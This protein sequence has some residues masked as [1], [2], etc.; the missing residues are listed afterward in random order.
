MVLAAVLAAG[1]GAR[2]H[3]ARPRVGD[4]RRA[5]AHAGAAGGGD[6]ELAADRDRARP[7][8]AGARGGRRSALAAM[9]GLALL[10]A[11]RP[12]SSRRW[13]WP[14]CRSACRSQAGGRTANL[15]VPLYVVIGAGALA[16]LVPR[17]AR[18]GTRARRPSA[19]GRWSGCC[20]AASCSTRVQSL[21]ADDAAKAFE[22]VV[23]FYVPFALLFVL[24]RGMEWTPRRLL[25][26]G[27]A[28]VVLA[29]V[30]AG[31]RL[32][33]VRDAPPAA[34]PEGDR[35]QPGRGVLP[36]QLAV[37]RPEH[38][39][40]LPGAGDARA[41]G[42]AAVG[43]SARATLLLAIGAL[44]RALGRAADDALAV[45]LRRAAAR[46]GR[47]RRGCASAA[48]YVLAPALVAVVGG[49]GARLRVP[50]RAAAGRSRLRVARRRHLRARRPDGG[51]RGPRAREA[52][53]RLG[54]G[55]LQRR[56]PPR[57][58]RAPARE[59]TSASHT[60]PITVAAEQ[61]LLGLA[62]YV[63]LLVLAFRR[64]L[65]GARGGPVRAAIA[66]RL[67]RAGAAHVAL[68]G[69]PRGPD[70]VDAARAGLG[71]GGSGAV[72][73]RAG[74]G[75]RRGSERAP[76]GARR[77][78]PQRDD[79]R[80][81]PGARRRWDFARG[82]SP[83]RRPRPAVSAARRIGRHAGRLRGRARVGGHTH[84]SELRLLLPPGVGPGAAQ[85]LAA[86]LRGLRRADRSIRSTSWS[87][88]CWAA[89]SAR[90][91]TARSCWS[92]FLA[93]AALVLGTYRLG[94]AV[95]GRWSGALAALFVAASA[96]F[97]LYAARGY[98]DLPFLALVVWAARARGR[99]PRAACRSLLVAGR[100]AAPEAWVLAG[101]YWLWCWCATPRRVGGL[102]ARGRPP[103]CSGALTTWSSPATRSTRCTPRARWPTT[104]GA[105]A[106]SQRVPGSFVSF[107]GATVRPPVALLAPARRVVLA[108]RPRPARACTCR[109]RCSPPACSRSSAPACS[110]SRSCRAT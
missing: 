72:A 109:W 8:G 3:R 5:R 78:R 71:A 61:G 37:L 36:R 27:G 30:F 44:R 28:L 24:L 15:L 49:G 16:W 104:S 101:L 93:H 86:V 62:A 79:R 39:R 84:V 21:Y 85:R 34:Q 89:C 4:A 40:A 32:L 105:C 47:A 31:D 67:R 23:F 12:A 1:R 91:R 35:V 103:R 42:G 64:L 106:G 76:Q 100:A 56:V 19:R 98:V 2:P 26:G 73:P 53:V 70:D 65:R 33:G 63:A 50:G 83:A 81:R 77:S 55:S 14:R 9:A 58:R 60:I 108:W 46:A 74:R 69:V 96:S 107:V 6:L 92:A 68:R 97:L 41:G 51:R 43:A 54:L 7:R 66:R 18:A 94:A 87:A 88:R 59:A 80:A 10:F 20:W 110:G 17:L 52:A 38:L 75:R 95:F 22:Q 82:R 57:A 102:R 13:R 29:L 90:A 99:G 45:E 25:W 11:R 48:S